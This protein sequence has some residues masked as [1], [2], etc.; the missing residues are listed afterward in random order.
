MKKIEGGVT[1][2]KGF[3]AA[4]IAAEIKYKNRS[5][6]AIVYSQTPCNVAG[7]FTTNVVKAAPVKWDQQVVKESTYAQAV[8]VNSGIANACTGTEGMNY[9]KET[10]EEA[11]KVLG[12]PADAV[13]V[14]STGVIGK[15]LPMDRIKTGVAK[16][17]AAKKDT[18]EAGTDAAKAIMTTD[19]C[20]KEI[21]LELEIGGTTVTIGGMAKGSGMIHPNMCTMLSFITTDAAI[22]KSA[23]QKALSDDVNDTYNMISV[24]GDTSTNDTVLVLANGMAGNAEIVEG[25]EDYNAFYAALHEVNEFLAKSMAG[26]GEGATALFEVNVIGAKSKE[27]AK[28]LSK[29]IACSNL[30]KAALAGHDANWGRILC[31]MGYS[32]A[33]FDPEKVD[34]FIESSAGKI[35]LV[36]TGVGTD[37]D[38][39]KATEIL[40]QPI[41]IATADMKMGT[42][43][44]TAWGCDLTHGYIDINADYRS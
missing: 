37:F 7:T 14:G 41:V 25:T 24:D 31:A 43:K 30:T 42:E 33:Q 4:G 22:R 15:Q 38:E 28:L 27:Q 5:D 6:M 11:A 3:E 39:K 17:A 21:A 12:I 1:A 32:G 18:L 26:D 2:A 35:Q 34:L 40:S 13:L 36:D 20:K 10:A 19:T 8:I 16:L 44:A 29:S 9:C 23:L